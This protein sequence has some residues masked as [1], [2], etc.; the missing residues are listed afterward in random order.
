LKIV[1]FEL[2]IEAVSEWINL[3]NVLLD[4]S[5]YLNSRLKNAGFSRKKY[6]EHYAIESVF[7]S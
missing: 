2:F 1:G 6:I 5:D 4:G 3:K 7:E